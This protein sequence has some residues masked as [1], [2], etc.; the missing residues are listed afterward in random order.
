LETYYN[1]LVR[2]NIPSPAP[3][4]SFVVEKDPSPASVK[5]FVSIIEA[6]A[7]EHFTDDFADSVAIDARYQSLCYLKNGDEIISCIMFTCLDGYPHITAMATKRKYQN[8]GYGKRLLQYFI[9]Y[10]TTLGFHDIEL[11][12]WSE[13]TRPVCSSTQAFYRSVGFVVIKEHIGLWAHDMV[14]VKMRKSW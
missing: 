2:D 13:R 9:A 8:R 6:Y 11:Y 3:P 12:A 5:Q 1:K 10:L 4:V 14:T 7:G